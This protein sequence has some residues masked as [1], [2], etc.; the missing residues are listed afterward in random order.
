MQKTELLPKPMIGQLEIMSNTENP[1][2]RLK[3]IAEFLD[4]DHHFYIPS[5]QR[6]YR[7][8]K[9]QVEDL[10]KDIWDF[11]KNDE[12]KKSD[13]YCLQPIVVKEDKDNRRWIVID[14][15]QRLT[16]LILLLNYIKKD[17]R[18]PFVNNSKIYE[19]KYA[20]REDMDFNNPIK[21]AEIGRASCRERV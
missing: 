13:F 11:A 17:S 8:D 14:G 6:G 2:F 16:T 19:I 20:T 18:T 21:D 5:F 1:N 15:Q 4:G 7:W 10:L 12:K 3:A 9:K